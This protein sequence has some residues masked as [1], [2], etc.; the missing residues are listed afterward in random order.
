MKLAPDMR[1]HPRL[2]GGLM[3]TFSISDAAFTGFRIARERP[4]AVALW[5]GIQLVTSLVLGGTLVVV[6]GPSLV[7]LQDMG[8]AATMNAAELTT[9]LRQLAPVYGLLLIYGLVFNAL[10]YGAMNRAVIRPADD[11]FGYFRLG[12]D[13][14]RQLALL[15]LIFAV[16]IGLYVAAILIAVMLAVIVALV[17]KAAAALVAVLATLAAIGAVIFVLVRLSL[18]SAQTF[19]TGKVNLFGSWALTR[20]RF[21][22][23]FG[24]YILAFALA[25]VVLVLG[26]VVSFAAAAVVGGGDAITRMMRPDVTS[27]TTLF[28]PA[29][30]AR[31]VV[32][33]VIAAM[34][35]PVLLTPPA[36]IYLRLTAGP[37]P[38]P[39]APS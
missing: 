22:S 29:M 7:R 36:A 13:E 19:A 2:W 26:F 18:A 12:A 5:A 3:E 16:V 27:L 10:L 28:S 34:V 30:L 6:A 17:A 21:W 14:L 39:G 31:T 8:A 20:G 33:A 4:R 37:A 35:L 23:I 9:V 25:C 24:A 38:K 11:R 15:L 32:N 1:L